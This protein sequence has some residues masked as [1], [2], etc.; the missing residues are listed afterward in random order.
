[1][2]KQPLFEA[3]TKGY[4]VYRIPGLAVSPGGAVL[5]TAEARSGNGG[6][7]DDND[8]V[9]RRSTDG[10]KTW[11][12]QRTIVSSAAYGDGPVSNFCMI[13]DNDAGCV[14]AVFC[15]NYERVFYTHSSDDGVSFSEPQEITA[16]VEPYRDEYPWRVIATGPS[17]GIKTR[18]GRLIVTLWMSDG[19]GTEFGA[20]KLGHRPSVVGGIYSDDTG[21]NWHRC[22]IV[23][24]HD[25]VVP[26]KG[27][28]ASVVNPSETLPV[29]LSD[30][31]ILFNIRS[32]SAPH[33]R[34][35]SVSP[36]GA[37][38]WSAP[39][40][41]DTLL[42]TVCMASIVRLDDSGSVLFTNPDNLEQTMVP[43][44]HK[45]CD[46]KRLSVK[47]ST[48]D[49]TSWLVSR[50]VEE[51]PSG[52]SDL[53]TL[54]DGTILCLYECG[55]ASKMFDDKYCMLAAFSRE[56]VEGGTQVR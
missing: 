53:A 37:T 32:E 51:G 40:F 33:R 47:L 4:R 22:E 54:P 52:Y 42:E 49:C 20:G 55:L 12:E 30:G 16:A 27:T 34:L 21:A 41:D 26:Y 56:W 45:N 24:R 13:T 19:S 39:A 5:A 38:G 14:H 50:V 1:M 9:L 17:H 48:D 43:S 46:R 8:V 3:R 23:A 15:H 10:G 31:R 44:G 18:S 7:W 11:D 29:E 2:T 35:V 6:D 25:Q 36:N 28:T